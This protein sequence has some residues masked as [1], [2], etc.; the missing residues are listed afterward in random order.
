MPSVAATSAFE[1]PGTFFL[2]TV[3]L[4]LFVVLVFLPIAGVLFLGEYE[5][6][7]ETAEIRDAQGGVLLRGTFASVEPEIKPASSP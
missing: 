7:L 5:E 6:R 3:F 2:A 1:V 4:V